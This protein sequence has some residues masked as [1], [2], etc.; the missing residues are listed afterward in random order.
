MSQHFVRI[1]SKIDCDWEGLSPVYR[2]YVNDE[3]FAER[4]WIWTDNY[5][6]EALQ[7][8]AEP[9]TYTIRYELVRPNLANLKIL[10]LS[11][12][13]GP[14]EVIDNTTFRIVG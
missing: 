1:L 7:V 3:L 12:N 14:A 2:L 13:Y 4:T 8:E 6:E 10:G 11:V 5:L 9:G